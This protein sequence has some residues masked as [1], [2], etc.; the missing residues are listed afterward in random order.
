M[1][2]LIICDDCGT[3]NFVGRGRLGLVPRRPVAC[4]HCSKTLR[5]SLEYGAR[6]P[7]GRPPSNGGEG[8][9]VS[10]MAEY[11][12]LLATAGSEEEAKTIADA[13]V[14]ESLVACVNLIAPVRSI[15]RWKG[16]ICD[17][18]EVTMI[19]KTRTA[20]IDTVAGRIKEL[21]SY[22]VPEIIALPVLAGL[23][24]YLKWID[25][26]TGATLEPGSGSVR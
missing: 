4:W 13:L 19:M 11:A 8:E 18:R 12:V 26:S 20:L 1:G 23:T 21:H 9:E 15:Y 5:P 22:E 24:E 17:D 2:I 10:D 14:S 7:L 6:D 16:E 25:E 3:D